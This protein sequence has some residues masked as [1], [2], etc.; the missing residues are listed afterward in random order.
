MSIF[1]NAADV[2][3]FALAGHA[4]VTLTS[5]KTDA[6]YTFKITEPKNGSDTRRFVSV[7]TGPD[8]TSDYTY[9]GCLE[10]CDHSPR[11]RLTQKSRMTGDSGPVRAVAFFCTR[12]LD[13]PEAPLPC[14][15]EIRHEGRCGKCGRAL[16]VPESID[17]GIGPECAAKMGLV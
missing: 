15:L 8:N 16:T 12:V 9:L 14:D 3:R 2:T 6:R 7:L 4:T 13:H 1:T 11:F 10:D 17:R 5:K